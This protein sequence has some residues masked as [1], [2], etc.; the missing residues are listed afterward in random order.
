MAKLKIS[1]KEL[2]KIISEEID[3]LVRR[4]AGFSGSAGIAGRGRGSSE[5][6]PLG[7]GDEEQQEEERY[8]KEQQKNQFSVR[9]DSR[10][11]RQD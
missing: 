2:R 1:L 11:T 7:L 6:P 5:I 3:R 8:G 9:V 10:K 4:S